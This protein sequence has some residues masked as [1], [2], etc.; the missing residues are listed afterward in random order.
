MKMAN[1]NVHAAVGAGVG[2]L[3]Y[4]PFCKFTGH[5]VKFGEACLAGGAGA[6]MG[7]VPDLLEP[8]LEPNHRRFFHSLA[9]VAL[10]V[11]GNRRTFGNPQVRHEEKFALGLGSAAYLSHLL[12]DGVTPKGLPIV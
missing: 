3:S 1:S 4:L 5:G 11:E 10:I 12:L 7:L 9:A 8:A 6:V 2:V